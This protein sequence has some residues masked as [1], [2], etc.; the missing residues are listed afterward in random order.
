MSCK[1]VHLDLATDYSTNRIL[2]V[3][4]RFMSLRG[5]PSKL[6]SVTGSQSVAANKELKAI[7]RGIDKNKLKE[8]GA[9]NEFDWDFSSPDTPWQIGC[10][11]ALV[12]AVKKAIK[13]AMGSQILMF[14][15]LMTL[16]YEVANLVNER[17]NGR[18][19]KDPDDGSL[20]PYH[21]L[22]G[23]ATLR[24]PSGPFVRQLI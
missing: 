21:L 22:L 9:E 3:L 1:A 12:K 24:I 8:F 13:N 6:R 19:S 10:S 17:P 23:R 11:E 2:I 15:E 5:Y 14:S 20:C 18:Q 16:F 4:R 7:I